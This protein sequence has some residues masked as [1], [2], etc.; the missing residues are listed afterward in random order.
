MNRTKLKPMS[1]KRIISVVPS[2]TE[3]L[4]DL[5][6]NEEVIGI[7]KFC[8]HPNEWYKTKKRIGGTKNLNIDLIHSLQPDL[9]LANKEE[10]TKEQIEELQ[11]HYPVYV[12]DIYNL[13]DAYTMIKDIGNLVNKVAESESIIKKILS[14][15]QN[16]E[17]VKYN[18]KALYLI[19]KRPYMAAGQS[20]FIHSMLSE[21]GYMNCLEQQRYPVLT[22]EEI[23]EL[24][25]EI[26][27]LSS[28]PYPFK[29][30]DID[31][32]K[33]NLP[34]SKICLVDGELFSWY[35]SRLCQSFEYFSKLNAQLV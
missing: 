8:I 33:F 30:K 15:K 7:T 23:C 32:L 34:H 31:E 29:Q 1:A 2:Q 19:W 6:L 26:I 20:T 17:I 14:A 24:N 27:F 5:G 9:I 21:A 22:V 3:L 35:G 18:L 28:E 25:P 10:N 4:Y 12:S 13:D 16:A 11:K